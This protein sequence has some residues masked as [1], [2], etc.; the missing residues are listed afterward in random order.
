MFSSYSWEQ[1]KPTSWTREGNMFSFYSW[2]QPNQLPEHEREIMFSSCRWKQPKPTS[3]TCSVP[4]AQCSRKLLPEHKRGI[5]PVPGD[6]K[7]ISSVRVA[8]CSQNQSSR[9]DKNLYSFW[10]QPKPTSWTREKYSQ[11]LW[12]GPIFWTQEKYVLFPAD[13]KSL[14]Q[15]IIAH[16]IHHKSI[17][18]EKNCQLLCIGSSLLILKR[19]EIITRQRKK[20]YGHVVGLWFSTCTYLDPKIC[21]HGVHYPQLLQLLAIVGKRRKSSIRNPSE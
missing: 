21:Y 4:I 7:K 8:W 3:W 17:N 6:H 18:P 12:P 19:K 2:E 11:F 13:A 10:D 5:S 9:Q 16:N 20:C 14:R 15:E 1:P